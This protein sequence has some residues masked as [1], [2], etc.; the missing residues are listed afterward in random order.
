[1]VCKARFLALSPVV[2]V[3]LVYGCSRL[4]GWAIFSATA[5]QQQ[6]NPWWNENQVSYGHF[7]TFWDAG[8]YQKIANTGYPSSLPLNDSGEV[9]Q[10][11]WAFYPLFPLVASGIAAILG[12]DYYPV[13]SALAL[14]AGF[15]AALVIYYLF[16]HALGKVRD[17]QAEENGHTI[18]LWATAIVA[19]APVAPILQVPYAESFNLIFLSGTLLLLLKERWV[20]AVG[21]AYLA[22]LS[23]PVGVPLGAAAG[24]YWLFILVQLVRKSDDNHEHLGR[25]IWVAVRT[26]RVQLMSALAI[27]AGA[28]IWPAIA[29]ARTGRIDAYTATE[30]AWRGGEHLAPFVPWVSQAYHYLGTV[31]YFV[32]AVLLVSTVLMLCSRTVRDSLPP[33]LIIWCASYIGYMLLFFNPQSST[34][35]LLL[36]LFPLALVLVNLSA[37]SAYRWMLLLASALAQGWWVSWLWHWKQLP[38]G[39]DYPP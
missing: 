4:W 23:R 5:M 20:L 25:R 38:A 33:V 16:L 37:S 35:R 32:L 11:E 36:P 1:M 9:L 27:C 29:W 31:G 2:Q 6:V 21:A 26:S 18:A 22:S 28:F 24:I 7:I 15:I 19:F 14:F 34:F 3:V 10:N 8:W 39:G 17:F 12:L 13:A 30:T